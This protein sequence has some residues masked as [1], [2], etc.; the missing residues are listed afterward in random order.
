MGDREEIPEQ[1]GGRHGAVKDP[2]E[3][4]INLLGLAMSTVTANHCP[5]CCDIYFFFVPPVEYSVRDHIVK[6][7]P[8]LDSLGDLKR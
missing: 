4:L 6:L 7:L 3:S 8:S 1:A 2:S 5:Y